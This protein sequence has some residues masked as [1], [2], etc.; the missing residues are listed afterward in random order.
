MS[1]R[2][3]PP[4][5]VLRSRIDLLPREPSPPALFTFAS[6]PIYSGHV[7]RQVTVSTRRIVF[8]SL[9][10]AHTTKLGVHFSTQGFIFRPEGSIFV[11]HRQ[12]FGLIAL[13]A[14]RS[15]ST[16][17]SPKYPHRGRARLDPSLARSVHSRITDELVVV[18][19][20]SSS[21]FPAHRAVLLTVGGASLGHSVNLE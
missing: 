20:D 1:N 19:L 17:R 9:Q 5:I 15:H 3:S 16:S 14:P 10:P 2:L 4:P 18:S 12:A 21:H 13:V 11:P 7:P 8:N 6:K